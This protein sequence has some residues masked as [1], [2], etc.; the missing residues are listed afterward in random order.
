MNTNQTELKLEEMEMVTGGNL[1]DKIA[2]RAFQGG[3]LGVGGAALAIVTISNPVGWEAAAGIV[4]AGVA[5]GAAT[6]TG[7]GALEDYF[8][9]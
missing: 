6:G 4:A 2:A 9:D 5:I 3:I 1:W 8:D 7:V